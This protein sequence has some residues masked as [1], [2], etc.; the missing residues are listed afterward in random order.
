MKIFLIRHATRA[1]FRADIDDPLSDQGKKEALAL[2]EAMKNSGDVPE[3]F[4]TSKQLHAHQTAEILRSSL[5]EKA[6]LVPLDAL[7][8]HVPHPLVNA[9]KYVE[10]VSNDLCVYRKPW[11]G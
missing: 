3:L 7:T 8:P 11:P 9:G 2:A 6:V 1:R 5:N 4:L 10:A